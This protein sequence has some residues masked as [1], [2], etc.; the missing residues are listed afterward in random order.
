MLKTYASL[1]SVNSIKATLFSHSPP[2]IFRHSYSSTK[3]TTMANAPAW[4]EAYPAPRNTSPSVME[5]KD[6]LAHLQGGKRPGVD[7]VVVDLR[8]NDYEVLPKRRG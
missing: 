1:Q 8:K 7:F 4:H 3:A 2:L 5:R 6:L